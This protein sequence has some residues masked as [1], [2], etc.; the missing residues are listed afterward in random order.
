ME[1]PVPQE[2]E[3][4]AELAD[5]L[6]I[7]SVQVVQS[8]DAGSL[9]WVLSQLQKVRISLNHQICCQHKIAM[10]YR[11]LEH[12]PCLHNVAHVPAHLAQ[13][14]VVPSCRLMKHRM[15]DWLHLREPT[16]I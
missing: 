6:E 16:K 7:K 11:T 14:N 12:Q 10:G 13:M 1:S 8:V 15:S 4:E 3:F 2:K 9:K 5:L